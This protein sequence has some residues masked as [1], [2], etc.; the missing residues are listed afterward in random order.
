MMRE[1]KD[2]LRRRAKSGL[3]QALNITT[4]KAEIQKSIILLV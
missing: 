2:R 3:E 4:I 1:T